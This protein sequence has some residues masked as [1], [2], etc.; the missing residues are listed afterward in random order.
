MEEVGDKFV[1]H[2]NVSSSDGWTDRGRKQELGRF[3][4]KLSD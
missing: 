3:A 1:F 2:L 4:E